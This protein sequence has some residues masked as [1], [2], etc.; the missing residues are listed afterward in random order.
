MD[1]RETL[2]DLITAS[3]ACFTC[4]PVGDYDKE[5][6]Q[7][8]ADY[9]IAHGVTVQQWIPA[10]EPPKEEGR[11]LCYFRYEPESPDVI[12]ENTYLRSKRWMSEKDKVT[13]WSPLPELPKEVNHEA[14]P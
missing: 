8:I 4:F 12:C 13:H 11:Y 14:E 7:K 3:G 2:I 6:K 5:E 10:T 1:V 9:L